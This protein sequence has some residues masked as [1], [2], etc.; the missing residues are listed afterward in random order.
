MG[1]DVDQPRRGGSAAAGVLPAV[2]N[3]GPRNP[4]FVGRDAT[5][6]DLR[7]RLR[8]GGTAVVQ[9]LHGM[10]GVGKTQ[11]AI[12]YVHRYAGVYDVVW[13]ISA[14]ETGLIGEQYAALAAELDLIP[15]RADTASAVG[16]LRA[17]LRGHGRWLLVLDNAESPRELRDWRPLVPGTP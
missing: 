13:W 8:S 17:Y 2:W 3:V 14:E 1:R 4:G 12:E 7:E 6:V 16:A 9:A 15:P 10:G 11:V 5:L